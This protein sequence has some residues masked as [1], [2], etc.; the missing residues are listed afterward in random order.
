MPFLDSGPRPVHREG[1]GG[2][3]ITEARRADTVVL[4]LKG[5]LDLRTAPS[6]RLQLA[7]VVRRCDADVVLDLEGV[8]FIDSTGLAAMLNALRRLTRAGRRLVLVC[9]DGPVRRILSLTRLDGTFTVHAFVEDAL[10]ALTAR[11]PAAA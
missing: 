4:S 1:R 6:L 2:L 11:N 8:E 5:E 3:L 10:E 9:P 7:D